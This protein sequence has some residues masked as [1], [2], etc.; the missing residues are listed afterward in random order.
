MVISGGE[1]VSQTPVAAPVGS[2]FLVRNIF[3]N[4]PGRRKFIDDRQSQLPNMIKTE[5]RRVA[6]C[7]PEVSM[8]LYSDKSLIY[9]LP[10]SSLLERIVGIIGP[11]AKKSL[12]EVGVETSIAKI[13][14]YVCRA[15]AAK[16]RADQ[17]L[18]VNGRYFKS[19]YFNK[20]V[21]KA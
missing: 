7:H 8:E 12:V 18:F 3:Y 16:V 5:F 1:F 13:E 2:Q 4:T 21:A 20:A 15:S 10:Q 11:T 19:P 14:G 17:Y 9:S 6:L